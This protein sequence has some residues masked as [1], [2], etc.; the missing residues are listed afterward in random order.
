MKLFRSKGFNERRSGSKKSGFAGGNQSAFSKNPKSKLVSKSNIKSNSKKSISPIPNIEPY[1]MR[2][3]KYLSHVHKMT[4]K[5]A[6]Q[7]IE[8]GNVK[9]NG[10][11]A[12]LGDKV[13]ETDKVEVAKIEVDKIH[14]DNFYFA[15]NKP[16]G[17][18]THSPESHETDI[19][20]A[21]LKNSGLPP[22][23]AKALFPIGRLDKKSEG[24]IIVTNDGR[25]TD[26]LLNPNSP[27]EKEYVVTTVQ[28]LPSF[29]KKVMEGGMKIGDYVTKP[30]IVKTINPK[31]FSIILTE[32]KRHQIRRMCESLRVDVR[33]L[34]RVR[35]MNIRLGSLKPNQIR[36]IEG[37]E[38]ENFLT[39]LGL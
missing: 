22:Y 17:I 12:K 26:R 32:G 25:V 6:D 8:N 11:I 33:D 37:K 16:V 3:N 34:K 4:R 18:V 29:F 10:K 5:I 13:F 20:S 14:K 30:T 21:L 36:K 1:P 39:S 27:H 38:L 28:E 23:V 9:I 24:L 19:K 35:V 15:Y 31:T 2:I 7:I